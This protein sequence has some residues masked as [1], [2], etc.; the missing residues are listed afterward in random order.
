MEEVANQ[1]LGSGQEFVGHDVGRAHRQ[2]AGSSQRAQTRYE[3]RPQLGDVLE[4]DRLPVEREMADPRVALHHL[5]HFRDHAHE[6]HSELLEGQIPLAIPV[7]V[8][9]DPDAEAAERGVGDGYSGHQA[10]GGWHR[11][12]TGDWLLAR[13]VTFLNHGS[14]GSCPRPVLERQSELREELERRPLTFLDYEL[15]DRLDAARTALATFLGARPMDVAFVPNATTGVNTVLRSISLQPGDEILTTDHE[16]NA[17]ANAA[18]AVAQEA[19]AKLVVAR[20]PMPVGSP[21]EVVAAITAAASERTRL[22]LFSHITSATALVWPVDRI[23]AA[24]AERGIETL[25]DGA[26]APGQVPVDLA[27]ARAAGLDLLHGQLPQVAVCAEG[28]WFLVGAARP[29]A[30]DQAA[31][32]LS[33]GQRRPP[34]ALVLH[35][36]GRLDRHARPDAIPVRAGRARLHGQPATRRLACPHGHQPSAGCRRPRCPSRG[37]GHAGPWHQQR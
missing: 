30:H 36:V 17:C 4:D 22:A 20:V 15:E 23:V 6:A 24:L 1:R 32:R 31:G 33:R 35:P 19:G 11:H 25:I 18:R 10:L 12:M 28:L 8:R 3:I 2:P 16:Y 34:G 14:F 27:R 5:D 21:D 26:H 37:A 7:R 9:H 13:D 29:P